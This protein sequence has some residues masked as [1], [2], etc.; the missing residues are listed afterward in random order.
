MNALSMLGLLFSF[1][2]CGSGKD[3]VRKFRILGVLRHRLF[4]NVGGVGR[5]VGGFFDS[6]LGQN[7][8]ID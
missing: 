5:G 4:I 1:S 7:S 3:R 8:S 6:L 2:N